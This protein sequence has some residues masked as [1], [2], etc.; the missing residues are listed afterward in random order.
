MSP[1]GGAPGRKGRSEEGAPR[2]RVYGAKVSGTA[3]KGA[4]LLLPWGGRLEGNTGAARGQQRI[5]RR[6]LC[7]TVLC[8]EGWGV[9]WKD[10]S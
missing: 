5:T 10:H 9:P 3:L 1:A 4:V 6:D 8:V 2:R 7:D